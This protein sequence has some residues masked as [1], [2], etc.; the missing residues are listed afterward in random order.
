MPR[1]I[2]T[3]TCTGQRGTEITV[4]GDATKGEGEGEEKRKG[5]RK[6]NEGKKLEASRRGIDRFV[7]S[8]I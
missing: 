7:W 1:Q 6:K 5:R 8:L 4:K 3:Y 2:Y